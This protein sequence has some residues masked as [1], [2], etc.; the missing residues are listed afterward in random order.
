MVVDGKPSKWSDG[1]REVAFGATAKLD[2]LRWRAPIPWG[3]DLSAGLAIDREDGR[4]YVPPL[5]FRS[6]LEA[7]PGPSESAGLEVRS[8]TAFD[9]AL[10]VVMR[11]RGSVL[12]VDRARSRWTEFG[13]SEV[14]FYRV[15][16]VTMRPGSPDVEWS[17]GLGMLKEGD[18]VEIVGRRLIGTWAK[19]TVAVPGRGRLG[20]VP[21]EIG[22][23]EDG[24]FVVRP[25]WRPR[26]ELLFEEVFDR[27]AESTVE[28][29]SGGRPVLTLRSR[30]TLRSFVPQASIP[31]RIRV[32]VPAERVDVTRFDGAPP[33]GFP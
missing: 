21:F 19:V 31:F 22:R 8:V 3:A 11:T 10:R 32:R 24:W 20:G 26:G 1:G 28:D 27:L 30:T 7:P 18:E 33:C 6:F 29:A 9:G 4:V 17:V 5:R 2:D 25:G 14:G 23:G 15:G 13:A 12:R 16:G